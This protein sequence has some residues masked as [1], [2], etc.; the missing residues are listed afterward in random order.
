[1]S[2]VDEWRDAVRWK[3]DG[4]LWGWEGIGKHR[5]RHA[6]VIQTPHNGERA[7]LAEVREDV[8]GGMPEA[9]TYGRNMPLTFRM[10]KEIATR[11]V[12]GRTIPKRLEWR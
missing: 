12:A 5:G 2:S 7:W 3:I 11:F 9:Y 6:L 1:M 4:P 10:A 8:H